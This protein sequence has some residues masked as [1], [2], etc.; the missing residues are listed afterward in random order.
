M[1][2]EIVFK[3]FKKLGKRRNIEAM[4]RFN[5]PAVKAFGVSAPDIRKIAKEIRIDHP[6]AI[7]LWNT[8]YHEAR[9][10]SAM[11]ADPNLATLSMLDLWANEIQNWAQCD[12]CCSEF[13]EKT[14]YAYKLPFRWSK[15]EKEYVRRAGIVMIAVLA[16]HHKSTSDSEFEKFFSLLK[17]YSTDEKNFVKKAVNWAIR[18]I[19]KRNLRLQK[20]AVALSKEIQNIPSK[21]AKWI[22]SDALR[23]LQNSKT[24]TMIKRKKGGK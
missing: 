20:K 2:K 10:L 3:R 11:I 7:E 17:R 6:L 15:S 8:E 18:Q 12:C 9:I 22:A 4:M 21:S 13:F 5:I 16:V 19:G 14:K 24:I 1:N 23:E